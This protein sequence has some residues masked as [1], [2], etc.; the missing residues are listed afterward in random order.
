MINSQKFDEEYA[1]ELLRKGSGIPEASFRHGQLEAIKQI[2]AGNHRLLVV[3]KT[4]WGKSFVYFIATKMLRKN[5]GGPALLISPLLSL[6]RNQIAAAERMGLSAVTI[7]SVNQNEWEEIETQIQNDEVDILLISPERLNNQQFLQNIL[8]VIGRKISMLVIDEAHCISDWGHDFRP[9][10]RLIQR[11]SKNLPSGHRLLA[12]TATANDRV[13]DDISDVLGPNLKVISGA[14]ARPSLYLQTMRF[15][16]AERL[17]WLADHI[18]KLAGSGIIYCLTIRDTLRIE[19]WLNTRGISAA[20]YSGSSSDRPRL[21]QQLLDDK[22]KVIVATTA[23]GMGFDKPN[24]AFVIHF[25]SPGSVVAYYQQ[26]G[27]AGRALAGAYGILLSGPDEDKINK[28][29]IDSAFPKIDEVRKIISALSKESKGLSRTQLCSSLNIR[30]KRIDSALSIMSLESPAPVVKENYKWILT[31][32]DLNDSFWERVQRITAIRQEELQ[33]MKEYVALDKGHMEFLMQ[34]LDSEP[35]EYHPPDLPPISRSINKETLKDVHVFLKRSSFPIEPRRIWMVSQ[36]LPIYGFQGSI[37]IEDRLEEG[38]VLF[39]WG[40][41]GLAK[42]VDEG[43]RK[44]CFANELVEAMGAM[45]FDWSPEPRPS[46]LTYVPSPRHPKLVPDFAQR[47]AIYL[48]IPLVETIKV[49]KKYPQQKTMENSYQQL[50][51]L[52]GAFEVISANILPGACYL[53]DDI[54][55]SRW[56]FT[57]VGSLLKKSEA[58]EIYPIALA[59]AKSS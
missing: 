49:V 17:A 53:I 50:K 43:K 14:L 24:L 3:Q 5:G 45:L 47:L 8:G 59:S 38:R 35:E 48:N 51:N 41:P 27:R 34:A 10:Y 18:P 6:M 26:V 30:P 40:D 39:F 19:H 33:Q 25:Q 44:G 37:P 2:I 58:A 13:K 20:A 36:A 22:L 16:Y 23:L 7:N 54:V 56:T 32:N 12:T 55:D 46:W 28:Y 4:G 1:Y 42:L 29:F 15:E 21:E 9:H 52:D 57:V 11:L 31:A